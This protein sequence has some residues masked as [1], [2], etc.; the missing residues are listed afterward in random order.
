MPYTL[1][2]FKPFFKSTEGTLG[3]VEN[4]IITAD[5]IVFWDDTELIG[6]AIVYIN[7][8]KIIYHKYKVGI[9]RRKR[10]QGCC[11]SKCS[12]I[13]TNVNNNDGFIK[14][15]Q[16]ILQGI[17]LP[18]DNLRIVASGLNIELPYGFDF[19][20][21]NPVNRE[22]ALNRD[23]PSIKIGDNDNVLVLNSVPLNIGPLPPAVDATE[24]KQIGMPRSFLGPLNYTNIDAI[25]QP[26]AYAEWRRA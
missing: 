10:V 22:I 19:T 23:G 17:V 3:F 7:D 16:L 6:N 8:A 24:N 4:E 15:K 25:N 18:G 5:K 1:D 2:D 13:R 26:D 14:V 9:N 21:K 20:N 11:N 12:M